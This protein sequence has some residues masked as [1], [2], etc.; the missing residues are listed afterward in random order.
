M[1]NRDGQKYA[2]EEEPEKEEV[3]PNRGG[4]SKT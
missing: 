4:G 2:K 3:I 1:Q